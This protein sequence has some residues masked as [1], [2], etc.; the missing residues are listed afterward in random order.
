[1]NIIGVLIFILM[2]IIMCLFGFIVILYII[3]KY[4]KDLGVANAK[5][6]KGI[7]FVDRKWWV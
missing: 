1:M 2:L 6:I 5:R 3:L 4:G 7:S